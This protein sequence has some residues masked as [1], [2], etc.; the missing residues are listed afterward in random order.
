MHERT[1]ARTHQNVI[2]E[3]IF[4]VFFCFVDRMCERILSPSLMDSEVLRACAPR[5]RTIGGLETWARALTHSHAMNARARIPRRWSREASIRWWWWR[6]KKNKKKQHTHADRHGAHMNQYTASNERISAG[7][8]CVMALIANAIASRY[9]S[10]TDTHTHA[11]SAQNR[12]GKG[13]HR[14]ACCGLI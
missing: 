9:A 3:H 1:H 11:R 7:V 13:A 4:V 14:N 10:R 8:A 6:T 12:S 2:S 5:S